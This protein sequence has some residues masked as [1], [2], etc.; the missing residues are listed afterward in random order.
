[1]NT[2][3]SKKTKVRL[4]TTR[5]ENQKGKKEA[6][7]VCYF[8]KVRI[9]FIFTSCMVPVVKKLLKSDCC[10]Y[11]NCYFSIHFHPFSKSLN[12]DHCSISD[13]LFAQVLLQR[14]VMWLTATRDYRHVCIGCAKEEAERP[15]DPTEPRDSK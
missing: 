12:L 6:D 5:Q 1:M 11:G 2:Q 9:F 14:G 3:R 8:Y 4:P 10:G 15:A 7:K 13:A